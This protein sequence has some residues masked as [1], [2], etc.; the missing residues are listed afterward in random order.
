MQL[1][2]I[3]FY[4][5]PVYITILAWFSLALVFNIIRAITK[6]MKL[7]I[8]LINTVLIMATGLVLYIILVLSNNPAW[9]DPGKGVLITIL[10]TIDLLPYILLVL[11]LF[12]VKN[13]LRHKNIKEILNTPV[14]LAIFLISTTLVVYYL[15]YKNILKIPTDRLRLSVGTKIS[16]KMIDNKDEA[17]RLLEVVNRHTFT[18]TTIKTIKELRNI[19][20]NYDISGNMKGSYYGFSIIIYDNKETILYINDHPYKV[21]NQEKFAQD[22]ANIIS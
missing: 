18:R 8:G 12:V 15:P 2:I 4:I 9:N 10:Y 16:S 13:I 7:D 14:I 6:T 3:N 21:K 5:L 11:V 17:D 22:L 1:F 20:K 19:S